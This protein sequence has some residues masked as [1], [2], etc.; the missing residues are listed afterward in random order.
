MAGSQ[1]NQ[2][3]QLKHLKQLKPPFIHILQPF[4]YGFAAL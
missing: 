1:V 4:F 3:D 2:K